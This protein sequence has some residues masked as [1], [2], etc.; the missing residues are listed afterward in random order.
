MHHLGVHLAGLI[1]DIGSHHSIYSL[2]CLKEDRCG[3]PLGEIGGEI[4]DEKLLGEELK[5]KIG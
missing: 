2:V 4:E 1:I 5:E 3:A